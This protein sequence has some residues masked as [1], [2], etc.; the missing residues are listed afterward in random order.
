MKR[1]NHSFEFAASAIQRAANSEHTYHTKRIIFWKKEQQKAIKKAKGAGVEIREHEITGG[2]SVE[3]ILDP[4][5]SR[6]LSVCAS[7]IQLHQG[8]ADRFQI[9]AAAYGTQSAKHY[10]LDPDDIVYFRLAGGPREE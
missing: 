4:S 7:K 9:E 1:D 2:K 8:S 10:E 3:V 5:V 6:R